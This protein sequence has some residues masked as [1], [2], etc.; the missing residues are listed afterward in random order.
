MVKF[1]PLNNSDKLQR[2][3]IL[4]PTSQIRFGGR[5]HFSSPLG[6]ASAETHTS[7]SGRPSARS[8]GGQ[9]CRGPGA[10]YREAAKPRPSLPGRGRAQH[11]AAADGWEVGRKERPTGN[12][13]R[14]FTAKLAAA[15]QE[16]KHPLFSSITT[17]SV[18]SKSTLVPPTKAM[19]CYSERM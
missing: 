5:R 12:K 13:R 15:R 4:S 8:R 17:R 6:T 1:F 16:K 19:A 14:E 7:A 2:K 18:V 9:A 11:T 3:P 10:G